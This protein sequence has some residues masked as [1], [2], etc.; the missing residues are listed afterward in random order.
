[1]TDKYYLTIIDNNPIFFK[2]SIKPHMYW[3]WITEVSHKDC[4]EILKRLETKYNNKVR[5][6]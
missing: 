5:K 3:P 1:M 2:G 6:H 4:E